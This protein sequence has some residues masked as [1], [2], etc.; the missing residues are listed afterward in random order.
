MAQAM[1]GSFTWLLLFVVG[2][3]AGELVWRERAGKISEVV[4]AF[5]TPDWI[6]LL[7]K[8]VALAAVI[9][10]FLAAGSLFCMGY[11]LLRGYHHLQPLLYLQFIGLDL[12]GFLLLGILAVVLQVWSNNKFAGYGLLLAF[13]VS[14]IVLSQQH[15]SDHLYRY[16][17]APDTPYSD[18]N[19][20]GSF[21][22][23]TLWF[24]AYWGCLAVALLVLGALYWLRG[25]VAGWRERTRVARQRFGL[26]ARVLLVLALA[27]F[28]AIGVFLFHNTHRLYRYQ[29]YDQGQRLA[30]NYEKQYR[31][32]MGMAQPRITD[33]KV[34]V[35]IY[36]AQRKADIDGHY[37]L[38]NKHD[39][40]IST[41]LV[42]LPTPD[43]R[44]SRI[45]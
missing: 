36:P 26:P 39:R 10:L 11:Q 15:L 21:W 9:V 40:P 4:D 2:F 12:L 18:M 31:K 24:R 16:G 8:V 44:E 1:S 28:A 20:F 41:L 7:S 23:G 42:Q 3:Y 27:G 5:P 45:D 43:S 33:V 37:V 30:A 22:I 29:T 13:I 14:N 25:N 19:G 32:Y 38:V 6:P 35:A 34:D 17:S